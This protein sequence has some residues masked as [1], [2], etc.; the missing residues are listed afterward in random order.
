LLLLLLLQDPAP[1]APGPLLPHALMPL[2]ELLLSG[3][4]PSG[5][6]QQLLCVV[7][8]L[9]RVLNSGTGAILGIV[10]E[11]EAVRAVAAA[12]PARRAASVAAAQA[13]L[14]LPGGTADPPS[15]TSSVASVHRNGSSSGSRSSSA[16][17]PLGA[18]SRGKGARR[19]R[20]STQRHRSDWAVVRQ[21][22]GGSAAAGAKVTAAA[23]MLQWLT[24]FSM[25]SL[26]LQQLLG[27]RPRIMATTGDGVFMGESHMGYS[28]VSHIW[29]IHG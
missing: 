18:A 14:H 4:A 16:A 24:G 28:W 9:L 3:S 20:S 10:R 23:D 2:E 27:L 13:A 19:S 5:R 7:P 17:V 29:G 6:P 26:L 15:T 25:E 12:W 11:M 1:L 8:S 22:V 21:S